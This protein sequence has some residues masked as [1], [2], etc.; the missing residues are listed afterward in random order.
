MLRASLFRREQRQWGQ[1]RFHWLRQRRY[2]ALGVVE[3][4]R[5]PAQASLMIPELSEA[6]RGLLQE[7]F[8]SLL[9]AEAPS[10]GTDSSEQQQQQVWKVP[11]DF[12]FIKC[13]STVVSFAGAAEDAAAAVEV[14][15]P[16]GEFRA[17]L[18]IGV[19]GVSE[20][21]AAA[22][23][24]LLKPMWRVEQMLLSPVAEEE[25][26]RR[27]LLPCLAAAA[28]AP[29]AAK[30]KAPPA[31]EEPTVKKSNVVIL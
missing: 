3:C 5:F 31:E 11:G 9:E 25:E 8:E 7:E 29:A 17:R 2:F 16:M 1:F 22:A 19:M 10:G 6:Q 13:A 4:V 26:P 15:L 28:A 27:G 23:S 30:R 14:P 12:F 21:L 18:A 20:N 24:G